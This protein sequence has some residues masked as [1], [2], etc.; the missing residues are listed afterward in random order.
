[1]D[2]EFIKEAVDR[3]ERDHG[4]LPDALDVLLSADPANF[5]Q[6]YLDHERRLTDSWGNR[7]R[8]D[9]LVN[10]E[11]RISCFGAD[12]KRGGVGPNADV[13]VMGP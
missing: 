4:R 3:Y 12:G 5:G 10:G 7:Y 11:Y 8:F 2:L 9:T 6:P 1:M 13:H